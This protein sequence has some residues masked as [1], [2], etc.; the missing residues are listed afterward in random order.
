MIGLDTKTINPINNYRGGESWYSAPDSVGPEPSA[1]QRSNFKREYEV[2]VRPT[3]GTE[4]KSGLVPATAPRELHVRMRQP[5]RW[6]D[7]GIEQQTGLAITDG[8]AMLVAGAI[9]DH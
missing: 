8:D 7:P 2:S 4:W 6:P 3:L 5:L 1:A 9:E